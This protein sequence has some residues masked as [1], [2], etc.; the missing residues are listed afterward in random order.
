M[1]GRPRKPTALKK[2]QGTLQPCRTNKKEPHPKTDLID[3][4]PPSYLSDT[5]KEVWQYAL[6]QAPRC[7]LTSLDFGIFSQWCVAYDQ[8]IQLTLFVK[9]KGTIIETE[10]GFKVNKMVGAL[11]RQIDTLRN[12]ERE[13]GFTPA[14][15]SKVVSF[16]ENLKPKN[17]FADLD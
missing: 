4:P 11:N 1:G 17:K 15:R 7:M 8:F 5:A 3:V 9:E 2:L 6:S 14:S 10:D 13:L 16:D 12:I